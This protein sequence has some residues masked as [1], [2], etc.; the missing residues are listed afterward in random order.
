VREILDVLLDNALRH[1]SGAV[2]LS[3]HA[4]GEWV[5]IAVGDE[6]R[7]FDEDPANVRERDRS[8][9][10]HGIGLALAQSLAAAEGG[11]LVLPDSGGATVVRLLMPASRT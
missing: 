1:G 7:G 8:H 4:R 11:R 6:G 10:G 3:V 5:S 2:D 9:D